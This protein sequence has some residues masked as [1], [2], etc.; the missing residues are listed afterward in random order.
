[1]TAQG[2]C[3]HRRS[4]AQGA[5]CVGLRCG[6][7]DCATILDYTRVTMGCWTARLC[8]I[9]GYWTALRAAE[10]HDY[11]GLRVVG[12][13]TARATTSCWIVW[14]H[15]TALRLTVLDCWLHC[16]LSCTRTDWRLRKGW[17]VA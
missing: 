17:M 15:W 9:V 5:G 7:L 11:A 4:A 10:L 8:W 2:L 3:L 12:Y 16:W 13:W 14:L 6:L 1:M